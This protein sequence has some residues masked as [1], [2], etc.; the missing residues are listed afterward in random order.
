MRNDGARLHSGRSHHP[1]LSPLSALG[2][3]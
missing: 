1:F 2:L 3:K